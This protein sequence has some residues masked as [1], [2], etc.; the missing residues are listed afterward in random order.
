MKKW[1]IFCLIVSF[2]VTG[3]G[4]SAVIDTTGGAFGNSSGNGTESEGNKEETQE[5]ILEPIRT[6]SGTPLGIQ[7]VEEGY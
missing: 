5:Q 4:N 3:C 1:L 2:L 6:F 7:R